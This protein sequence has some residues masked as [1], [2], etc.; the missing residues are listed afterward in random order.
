MVG[1][2]ARILSLIYLNTFCFNTAAFVIVCQLNLSFDGDSSYLKGQS[3][4]A[5]SKGRLDEYK[6]IAK[7][8]GV[9][10][11]FL[12]YILFD[13]CFERSDLS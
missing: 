3:A 2:F 13:N 7:K 9:E 12:N 11:S 5:P 10:L 8:N 4:Y 6:M 1:V